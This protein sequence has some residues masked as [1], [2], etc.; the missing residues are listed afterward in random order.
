MQAQSVSKSASAKFWTLAVVALL[1]SAAGLASLWP[2]GLAAARSQSS[3]LTVAGNRASGGEAATD[4]LL[5]AKLNPQNQAAYAGLAR[6]QIAM[7]HPDDAL[8]SLHHAGNGSEVEQLKLRTLLEL[9]RLNTAASAAGELTTPGRSDADLLLAAEA[10]KLANKPDQ[11]ATLAPRLSSPDASRRLA[12]IQ[13]DNVTFASELYASGLLKRS[14]AL[15]AK[16]PASY[17]T[18]LLQARINLAQNANPAESISHLTAANALNPSNTE[19]RGLL[20]QIYR[21]QNQ[22]ALAQQQDILIHQLQSGRP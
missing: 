12:R 4:Y 16:L 6:L 5:A 3:Q 2:L 11:A 7:G 17:N 15:L 21:S 8:A 9:G 14:S 19:A 18:H 1:G 13:A 10:F 20:A 22:P